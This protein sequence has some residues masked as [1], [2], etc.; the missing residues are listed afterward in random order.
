MLRDFHAL[1]D[2]RNPVLGRKLR[3][4]LQQA[5]RKISA[6][7]L[8]GCRLVLPPELEKEMVVL[9]FALPGRPQLAEVLDTLAGTNSDFKLPAEGEVREAVLDAACGLTTTE[10]EGVFALSVIRMR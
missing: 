2:D 7:W 9:D 5:K 1:L 3:E 4:V 10:A 8:V 6:S